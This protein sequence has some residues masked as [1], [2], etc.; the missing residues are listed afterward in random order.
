MRTVQEIKDCFASK[1]DNQISE[2]RTLVLQQI[3]NA[4]NISDLEKIMQ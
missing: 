1:F 2:Y 3:E 4:K